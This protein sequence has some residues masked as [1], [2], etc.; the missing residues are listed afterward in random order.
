MDVFSHG[1][2]GFII[3]FL[4]IRFTE[5]NYIITPLFLLAVFFISFIPDL[6]GLWTKQLKH[7]PR[8]F[9]HAPLFW[10]IILIVGF[11]TRSEK[12][13]VLGISLILFHLFLDY[14]TGRTTGIMIFYPF[15]KKEY[16]LKKTHPKWGSINQPN[17]FHKNYKKYISH[18]L[19]DK[20]L[21]IFQ[22]IILLLG[23]ICFFAILKI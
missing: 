2:S 12:Y 20:K 23:I 8:D 18:F 9:L 21:I 17:L 19:E 6:S 1:V 13:F 4:L 3:L 11:F 7:H 5:Y 10:I 15:K 14:I 16:S 22:I